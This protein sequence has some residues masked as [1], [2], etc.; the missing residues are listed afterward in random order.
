MDGFMQAVVE[1]RCAIESIGGECPRPL[2]EAVELCRQIAEAP[3]LPIGG[4]QPFIDAVDELRMA[5]ARMGARLDALREFL[6]GPAAAGEGGTDS[7]VRWGHSDLTEALSCAVDGWD[8]SREDGAD[9]LASLRYLLMGTSRPARVPDCPCIP[10]ASHAF[11]MHQDGKPAEAVLAFVEDALGS[12]WAIREAA[13]ACREALV[14]AVDLG[15]RKLGGPGGP[16]EP[17]PKAD[18]ASLVD[19]V[20]AEMEEYPPGVR[21]FWLT[22]ALR[23]VAT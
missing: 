23:R 14:A 1:A 10:P 12:I 11:R 7:Q 22:R 18:L 6:H 13:C 3:L 4:L 9:G 2:S 19:D 16:E 21:S 15:A 8:A 5:C 20:I 17:E